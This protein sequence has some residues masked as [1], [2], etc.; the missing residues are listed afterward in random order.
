MIVLSEKNPKLISPTPLIK[1]KGVIIRIVIGAI[2]LVMVG[3]F[4]LLSTRVWDP[5][6][7]PFRPSPQETFSEMLT[8]M[9]DLESFSFEINLEN[10]STDI[11]D[12]LIMTLNGSLD[13][14]NSPQPKS[15]IGFTVSV[16]NYPETGFDVEAAYK[17]VRGDIY[18]KLYR[19]NFFMSPIFLNAMGLNPDRVGGEWIRFDMREVRDMFM[20]ISGEVIEEQNK[21]EKIEEK[22]RTGRKRIFIKKLIDFLRK[23]ENYNIT[24]EFPDQKIEGKKAYHYLITID[25]EKADELTK[26]L[27][28]FN[29]ESFIRDMIGDKAESLWME[30]QIVDFD[31]MLNGLFPKK[32]KIIVEVWIGKKDNFLYQINLIKES[33]VDSRTSSQ[34]VLVKA[35]AKLFNFENPIEINSPKGFSDFEDRFSKLLRFFKDLPVSKTKQ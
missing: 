31:N 32:G 15:A 8:N 30:K 5:L 34:E 16:G 28:Q 25:E 12:K 24:E 22:L 33:N 4:I 10:M 27:F 14:L 3:I 11:K 29:T 6:W 2:L 20:L 23:E 21:M 7:N 17:A 1:K 13:E 26:E 35:Y 18:F 19:L 9:D